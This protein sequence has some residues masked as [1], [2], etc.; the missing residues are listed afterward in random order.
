VDFTYI[1][2]KYFFFYSSALFLCSNSVRLWLRDSSSDWKKSVSL[3]L[4]QQAQPF[5]TIGISLAVEKLF[6]ACFSPE[7]EADKTGLVYRCLNLILY[8]LRS[9]RNLFFSSIFL[10]FFGFFSHWFDKNST[11]TIQWAKHCQ[12]YVLHSITV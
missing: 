10:D 9:S 5:W 11:L 8:D 2:F 4:R 7:Q 12:D 1:M 3:G 6:L